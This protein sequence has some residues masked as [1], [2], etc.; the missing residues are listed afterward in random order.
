MTNKAKYEML[1]K[2]VSIWAATKKKVIGPTSRDLG[3]PHITFGKQRLTV[4]FCGSASGQM[5]P[6]FLVYPEPKPRGYNPLSGSIDGTDLA[7]T[8]KGGWTEQ[9]FPSS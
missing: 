2:Q 3:V 1:M 5:M 4:M 9:R 7:Y 8:K 6:P